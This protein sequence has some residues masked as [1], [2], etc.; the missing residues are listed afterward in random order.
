MSRKSLKILIIADTAHKPKTIY[1][2]QVP[3]L[4]KGFV[5]L[6]HDVRSLSCSGILSELSVLKS[7]SL[8]RI[9]YKNKMDD[10]LCDYA[11]QYMPNV[12]VVAFPRVFDKTSLMHIREHLPS[13]VFVGIDGDLWPERN[14]NR[15]ET[16]ELLDILLATNNG[17]SLEA[18]RQAGIAK[19]L[20]MP[21]VC[22]PDIEYRYQVN[23]L[24]RCDI[25]WT[26]KVR[27][28]G[29]G[30]ELRQDIVR[31]LS[32]RAGTRL[33]GCLDLAPIG[34]LDYLHAISGAKIGISINADNTIPLYHSDRFTHYAACGTM[35]LAKRVPQTELLMEDKKHV[36]YF[37]SAEECM[38][39]A[40]WYLAHEAERK[41]I[42]DAGM[43]RCHTLFN[44]TRIAGYMLDVISMGQYQSP[45]GTFS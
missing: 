15:L 31:Q 7:R 11:K 37:D 21:N 13:S 14:H 32:S 33:F 44:S 35:V 17:S 34:G 28:T 43:E 42:A 9:L 39:L 30:D 23:N 16:S 18:Y 2:D 10:R 27:H 29:G 40:D 20:F 24:N 36:V 12:I 8:T 6:G 3:K 25:L 5:R 4:A 26:G 22:D 1:I 45:W 41:K 38:E 19:C